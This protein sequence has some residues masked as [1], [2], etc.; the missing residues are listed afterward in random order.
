MPRMVRVRWLAK[1][2]PNRLVG[3]RA[4]ANRPVSLLA[5]GFALRLDERYAFG[6][7]SGENVDWKTGRR[8]S[9]PGEFP[10]EQTGALRSAIVFKPVEG[11]VA[12]WQAGFDVSASSD[13]SGLAEYLAFI[14]GLKGAETPGSRYG[15]TMAAESGETHEAMMRHLKSRYGVMS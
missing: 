8:R 5:E 9:A 7:R 10:Q 3:V 11:A 15:L 14:E 1:P 2:A 13:P 6:E 4:M 12:W